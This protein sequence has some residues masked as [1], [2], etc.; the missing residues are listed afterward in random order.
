M[1]RSSAHWLRWMPSQRGPEEEL[2]DEIAIAYRVKAVLAGRGEAQI[3]GERLPINRERTSRHAPAPKGE[4]STRPR[5][6]ARRAVALP[7]PGT[8]QQPVAPPHRLRRL[9][10]SVAGHQHVD[11]LFRTVGGGDDQLEQELHPVQ[12]SARAATVARRSRPGHCGCGRCGACPRPRRSARSAGARRSCGC[13][14]RSQWQTPRSDRAR[15]RRVW[16]KAPR[17]S[18]PPLSRQQARAGDRARPG[19]GASDV[20][21]PQPPVEG[22]R[23]VETGHERVGLAGEA[24]APEW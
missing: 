17:L 1:T 6:S 10:V 3:G 12:R 24:A 19:D 15:S 21:I 7:G 22:Q 2:S 4:T 16:L 20:G 8:A 18:G 11:L 9:K 13:P 23:R 14:R 5:R